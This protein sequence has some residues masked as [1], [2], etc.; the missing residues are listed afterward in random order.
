MLL[1]RGK[2]SCFIH[3]LNILFGKWP[4]SSFDMKK[5]NCLI[6]EKIIGFCLHF[7]K[8]ITLHCSVSG[9]NR[10][11]ENRAGENRAVKIATVIIAPG[12][13]RA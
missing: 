1:V 12:N 3:S 13:N 7:R 11:G 8:K 5:V 10:A 6:F 9:D 2:T 4:M